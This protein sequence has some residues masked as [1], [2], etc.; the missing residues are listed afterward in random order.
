M[1]AVV[2]CARRRSDHAA[3]ELLSTLPQNH[4]R[5]SVIAQCASLA[6]KFGCGRRVSKRGSR[7]RAAQVVTQAKIDSAG[8]DAS[9]SA[10]WVAPANILPCHS[11]ARA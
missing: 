3:E 5:I 1:H 11:G 9:G 7:Q 4:N 10:T 8:C 2:R 6:E